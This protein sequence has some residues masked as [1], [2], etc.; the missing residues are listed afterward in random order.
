MTTT[1]MMTCRK[2]SHDTDLGKFI[3]FNMFIKNFFFYLS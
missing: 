3:V 1:T 2:I